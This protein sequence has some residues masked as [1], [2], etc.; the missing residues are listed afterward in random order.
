MVASA[1]QLASMVDR[2]HN[3]RAP[4]SPRVD[5]PTVSVIVPVR[6]NPAG[7]EALVAR[8]AAQ[9]LPLEQFEVVIGDDGSRRGS[10]AHFAQGG[11]WVRVSHG[12]RHT[13]YAARNRAVAAARGSVLAFCDSDCLPSEDWL[14]RGLAALERTDVAAGE[15]RF[16]VTRP[17][18]VWALLTVDMFLDQA[19]NVQLARAVTANLFLRRSLFDAVGGFDESLPSGGDYDFVRRCVAHGLH[20]SYAADAVV[21]HPAINH[22]RTFL[23]KVWYTNR[24]R[25]FRQARE[26]KAP[27]LTAI[28]TFVPVLGVALARRRALRPVWKLYQPRF[29]MTGLRFTWYDELWA[30]LILYVLVGYVAGLGLVLGWIE[31][32]RDGRGQSRLPA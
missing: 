21:E 2:V 10:L 28:L 13:S 4:A 22:G 29:N 6:D 15:V 9:S 3:T 12:G 14:E 31:G 5:T 24:W 17:P 26:R 11:S 25:A 23:R 16:F 32:V 20:L 7:I 18:N 8:L 1:R 27:D 30:L 19:R